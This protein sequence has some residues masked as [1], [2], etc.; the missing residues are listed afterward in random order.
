MQKVK[1]NA[2]WYFWKDGQCEKKRKLNLPHD[3]MQ[4]ETRQPDL[5]KGSGSGFFP[6]GKKDLLISQR[7]IVEVWQRTGIHTKK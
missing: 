1:F 7:K 5:P 3:A 2:D 4:E 6:G